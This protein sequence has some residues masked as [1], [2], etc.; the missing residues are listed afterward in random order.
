MEV[1][2]FYHVGPR[3]QTQAARL[4]SK[5]LYQLSHLASPL[6]NLCIIT[7]GKSSDS[8]Y[9]GFIMRGPQEALR[10]ALSTSVGFPLLLSL[11]LE[12]DQGQSINWCLCGLP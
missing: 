11:R 10:G 6:P 2:S 9:K 1:S 12:L 5:H 4:G 7:V 3:D 8:S